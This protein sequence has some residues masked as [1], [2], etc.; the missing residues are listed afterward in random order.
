MHAWDTGSWAVGNGRED[1]QEESAV[2]NGR[3]ARNWGSWNCISPASA[4]QGTVGWGL[5]VFLPCGLIL[6][7]LWVQLEVGP[8]PSLKWAPSP[9]VGG[10]DTILTVP[11]RQPLGSLLWTSE[12]LSRA[13]QS[14]L[15]VF[16]SNTETRK[17]AGG[18]EPCEGCID[19]LKVEWSPS[20]CLVFPERKLPFIFHY[21]ILLLIHATHENVKRWCRIVS[22]IPLGGAL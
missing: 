9:D 2:E 20:C 17:C 19:F 11:F 3:N 18:F 10:C 15:V 21:S 22:A 12:M 16:E 6:S 5:L 13:L 4:G 8:L 7:R 1:C 14:A